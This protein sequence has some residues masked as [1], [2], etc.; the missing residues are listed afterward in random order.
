MI[1]PNTMC[2]PPNPTAIS[3]FPHAAGPNSAAAPTTIKQIPMT[4]TIRTENAPPVTNP[5]P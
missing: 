3:P 4:G 2:R 1:M 5:A